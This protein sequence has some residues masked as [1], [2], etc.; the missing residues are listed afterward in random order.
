MTGRVTITCDS[1][2]A[3]IHFSI[4]E[5]TCPVYW[6]LIKCLGPNIQ[7]SGI[8]CGHCDE[9]ILE[10]PFPE[11]MNISLSCKEGV[12]RWYSVELDAVIHRCGPLEESHEEVWTT[13]D[14]NQL[15]S[16]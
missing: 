3:I 4:E 8:H 5:H 9:P 2:G 6:V 15:I 16:V 13:Q 14:L 7:E 11:D 1:T 10:T 12:A